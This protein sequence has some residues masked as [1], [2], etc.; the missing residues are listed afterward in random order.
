MSLLS[1]FRS[2]FKKPLPDKNSI[3]WG[4]KVLSD[5]QYKLLA[6]TQ[7]E[8][9]KVG[10]KI[11]IINLTHSLFRNTLEFHK[12]VQNV[13]A[14]TKFE[15]QMVELSHVDSRPREVFSFRMKQTGL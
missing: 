6:T 1:F 5:A 15:E 9:I 3:S 14:N 12:C 13:S 2:S 10:C 8:R 11:K 7:Q 4:I